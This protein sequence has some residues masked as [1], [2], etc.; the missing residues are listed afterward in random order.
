MV[1]YINMIWKWIIL[2]IVGLL[3]LAS[4]V[5]PLGMQEKEND[6]D[7]STMDETASVPN[8]QESEYWK[9]DVQSDYFPACEIYLVCYDID[10]DNYYI[11]TDNRDSA[12]IHAVYNV[13]PMLGRQ[14]ITNLDVFENGEPKSMYSFPLED[15][16][17]WD[18]T[19]FEKNLKVK[20]NYNEEIQTNPGVFY[21]FEI[22]A[23]D[24][25]GFSLEYD[26]I[27]D[28]GWFS[29]F[30]AVDE[31]GNVLYEMEII[32][33]GYDYEGTVYF[34]RARDLFD[35][36]NADTNKFSVSHHPKYGDYDFLAVGLEIPWYSGLFVYVELTGPTFDSQYYRSYMGTIPLG[37]AMEIPNINGE[38]SVNYGSWPPTFF[39]GPEVNIKVAG[40]LEYSA[41]L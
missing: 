28:L 41:V 30:K 38:W 15:G 29:K 36:T 14:T 22:I 17:S 7:P 3:L 25:A 10:D 35:S 39:R 26:Y 32:E 5:I 12:L 18:N 2:P 19:L 16:A 23:E 40:V 11:G 6:Y 1:I 20:A 37:I 9:Y 21:G 8:W 33:H 34:M 13:N 31:T 4:F 27:P 24:E